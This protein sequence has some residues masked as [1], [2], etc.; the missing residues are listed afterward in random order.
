VVP[1]L[2]ERLGGPGAVGYRITRVYP[3]TEAERAG[4]AVGDVVVALDGEPLEPRGIEDSGLL[5][6]RVRPLPIG[7][8]AALTVLRDGARREVRVTL[9]RTRLSPE[10]A[11]R[12]RDPD[13]EISAREVT[14]FDRDDQRWDEGVAGVLV[15][16]I[17]P[18]G[19]AGLGGVRPGDLILRFGG[20]P[21][22]DLA[23]FE[24]A[25]A[26]AVETRAE[27]VEVVVL[28]GARTHFLYLEPEWSPLPEDGG[29]EEGGDA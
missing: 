13:F 28:R 3:G 19:W 25:L 20:R 9:E 8:E 23:G 21:V 15:E 7:G 1:R 17:E 10:E 16:Q 12:H 14:F 29:G 27:R 4:L 2:A 5:A 24:R 18:A 26:A 11:A 22:A 6:R